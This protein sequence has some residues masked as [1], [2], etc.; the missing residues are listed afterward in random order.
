MNIKYTFICEA[1]DWRVNEPISYNVWWIT[2]EHQPE[3][4]WV[5]GNIETELKKKVHRWL[6]RSTPRYQRESIRLL[7]ME[8]L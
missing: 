5:D 4:W 6:N 1:Y 7:K 8:T 2:D 3:G